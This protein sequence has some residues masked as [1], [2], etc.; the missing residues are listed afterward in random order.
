MNRVPHIPC[1]CNAIPFHFMNPMSH[2]PSG[3]C[4]HAS[5]IISKLQLKA[6]HTHPGMK[7]IPHARENI[8]AFRNG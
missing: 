4:N 5:G 2:N 6:W 1:P 8:E 7:I 3:K